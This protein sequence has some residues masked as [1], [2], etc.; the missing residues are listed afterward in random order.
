MKLSVAWIFDHIDR[1]WHKIDIAELVNSF[2]K[3]TAEIENWYP[4][5]FDLS[6]FDAVTIQSIKGDT[7]TAVSPSSK[8]EY[9]L[10]KRPDAVQDA[11]YIIITKPKPRW[12][13][14]VDFG[15]TK[16]TVLAQVHNDGS[17]KTQ[18]W[19]KQIELHDYILEIDNKSITHRPDLWGHRGFAREIA[20][21]LGVKLKPLNA[22]LAPV[23][24][25]AEETKYKADT[26]QPISVSIEDTAGCSRFA[27]YYISHIKSHASIMRMAI[28]LAR[29]D[30]KPINAIVDVTNYTMFDLGQPMH[31]FDASKIHQELVVR[32]ARNKEKLRLIDGDS[33]ELTSADIVI[34]DSKRPVSLAGIM[35]GLD[36]S[37]TKDTQYVI[38]ES[39]HF[40]ATTIR[41]S[42][43][44]HKKR[45]EGSARW[46]KG[47]DPHQN[48]DGLKRSIFLLKQAAIITATHQIVSVGITPKQPQHIEVTHQF[49]EQQLGTTIASAFIKKILTKLG[50]GIEIEKKPTFT[51]RITVPTYRAKDIRIKE[52]IV[53]EIGRFFG[54]QNIPLFLPELP[55]RPKDLHAIEQVEKIRSTCAYALRMHEL[56]TYALYD[57]SWLQELTWEP[58]DAVSIKNPV[59]ENWRRLVTSLVPHLL[60]AIEQNPTY[61]QLR[62]FEWGRIWKQQGSSIE[63]KK[64]L[65]SIFFNRKQS[66]DFYE[67]K[68]LVTQLFQVI[69]VPVVWEKVTTCAPW[70]DPQQTAFIMHNGIQ[71]G[72]AGKAQ[73][74][75][76]EHCFNGDAFIMECDG[77]FL[78]TWQPPI[79][80][81]EAPSKYPSIERD[82]SML[83]PRAVTVAEIEQLITKVD[84][85]I[86]HVVLLDF[87]EKREWQ[88]Q[89]S[90]T[91][92]VLLQDKT[93]TMT[94]EE[95]DTICK[96]ITTALHKLGATIR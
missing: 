26:V 6:S 53:E 38:L 20:A 16:E 75:F 95:A 84:K 32:R 72:I 86:A 50:F 18:S 49:I 24:I 43:L 40:D 5:K 85:R 10:P 2:N 94:K 41:R 22:M 82:I 48:I 78:I 68:E 77:D 7:I 51:Y 4:V 25:V 11:W 56:Y 27:T 80:R 15:G 57:E 31:A 79:H 93:K 92:R 69:N 46:E 19:K 39:A 45:T 58:S 9:K 54:Y 29:V 88:D 47:L 13:T 71:V 81:F 73:K 28:R 21:I 8:K 91:V 76:F 64:S 60:K 23:K 90:L 36:T 17:L 87:F 33:L 12:A 61:D 63:E 14:L 30:G 83:V 1:D 35:G 62:F 67:A 34:A 52:D 89:K 42:S 44:A 70:F 3:T 59:S 55:S 66:I 96:H 37:I 65:T 74:H